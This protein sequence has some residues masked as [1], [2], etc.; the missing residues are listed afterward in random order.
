MII[1]FLNSVIDINLIIKVITIDTD[2][3]T[4]STHKMRRVYGRGLN[5]VGTCIVT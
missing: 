5:I 2:Y 4:R 3:I 1:I